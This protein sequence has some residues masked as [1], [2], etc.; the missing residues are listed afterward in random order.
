MSFYLNENTDPRLRWA[1]DTETLVTFDPS[2]GAG[3]REGIDPDGLVPVLEELGFDL[4][5]GEIDPADP[6]RHYDEI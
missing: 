4:S 2:G 1:R 5:T 3:W 6:R